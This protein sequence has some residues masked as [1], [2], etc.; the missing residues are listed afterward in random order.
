MRVLLTGGGGFDGMH[1]DRPLV[2]KE[3]EVVMADSLN[4]YYTSQLMVDSFVEFGV[5]WSDS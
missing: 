3:H 5:I 2:E 4:D 1:V